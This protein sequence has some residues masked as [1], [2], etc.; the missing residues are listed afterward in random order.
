VT[1]RS[2]RLALST[3]LNYHALEWDG[4]GETTFVLVHG[5]SDLGWAWAPVAS[6]LAAH[7]HVVAPDL[8]G[9]GD[10]DWIGAGGYYHFLD[11]IAD[12]DDVIAQTARRHVVLVGHS[13]G[14]M[15]CGYYAGTRPERLAALCVIEGLGPPDLEGVEGPA[16]TSLWLDAWKTAM[17]RRG[18]TKPLASYAEAAARLRKNDPR[19]DEETA[20]F[21]AEAGTRA[22]PDGLRWKHDPLHYTSGPYPFRVAVAAKYWARVSSPV[23]VVDGEA[24]TLNLPIAERAARRAHFPQH[25]HVIVPDAGHAVPRHQPAAVADLLLGLARTAGAA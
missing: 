22:H 13:M 24:S 20:L 9:H 17:P 3:G 2:L 14:G 12:L 10:S 16:R 25:T 23:L 11:Y 19:L 18:H 4:P 7:A 5:F 21:L 15:I 8:R 1:P 6:R